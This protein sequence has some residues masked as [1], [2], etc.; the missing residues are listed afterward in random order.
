MDTLTKIGVT[1]LLLAGFTLQANAVN[2]L[3]VAAPAAGGNCTSGPMASYGDVGSDLDTFFTNGSTLCVAGKYTG[4]DV[5]LGGQFDS[6][7]NWSDFGLP[8]T[9]DETPRLR[10]RLNPSSTV[11][12]DR[13]IRVQQGKA[14][15]IM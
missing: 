12:T 9:P 10:A 5:K 8:T 11:E 13:P 4:T 14:R 15:D 6:G 2:I 3:Q 7:D 1:G